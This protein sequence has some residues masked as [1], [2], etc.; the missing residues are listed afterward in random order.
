MTQVIAKINRTKYR[1]EVRTGN[2]QLIGD[3]PIPFGQDLGPNPYDFLLISLGTCVAMTL[4]MYADR[5]GWDMEEVEVQLAQ[6]RVYAEDCEDCES[7]DGYVHMIEKKLRF[8]GDLDDKQIQ[9]LLEISDKCPVNKTLTN[10]IKI[11]TGLL[12]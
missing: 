11:N 3:E 6:S 1:T 12:T 5:K 2:H 8:K 10:E 4:R 9:R 7:T